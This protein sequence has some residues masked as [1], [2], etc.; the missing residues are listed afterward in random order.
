L[1][2]LPVLDSSVEDVNAFQPL[3][4]KRHEAKTLRLV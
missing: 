2:T 3:L 1:E 4:H